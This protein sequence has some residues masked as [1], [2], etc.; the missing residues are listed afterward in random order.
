MAPGGMYMPG[1]PL[2]HVFPAVAP[3]G[4]SSGFWIGLTS[5]IAIGVVLALLAGFFIG[6]GSRLSNDTIQAKITSQSQ[7]DQIAQQQA[8]SNQRHSMFLREQKAIN[9]ASQHAYS[10]GHLAGYTAGQNAGYQAGQNSGYSQGQ[11]SG[12]AN[13]YAQ[14]QSDGLSQGLANNCIFYN[15]C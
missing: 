4:R 9:R 5:A 8:L 7:A 10:R 1:A 13:G 11:A 6:R 3:R 15:I 12:Q 2:G 14:G